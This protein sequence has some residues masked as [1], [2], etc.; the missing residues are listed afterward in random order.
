MPFD[1]DPEDY[2]PERPEPQPE[3]RTDVFVL[4]WLVLYVNTAFVLTATAQR[5]F[6]A[7]RRSVWFW[8][9]LCDAFRQ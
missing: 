5:N 1:G 8:T 2:Q 7:C 4:P 3:D 9:D 6:E